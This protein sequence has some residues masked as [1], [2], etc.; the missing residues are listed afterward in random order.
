MKTL[1]F[2]I[3]AILS[4]VFILSACTKKQNLNEKVINII[5]LGEIKGL[6][7]ILAADVGTAAQIGKIYEGLLSYHWLKYPY[8][9][10]PNLAESMPSVSKDGMTYTFK[11]RKGVFFQDNEAFP[12]G[13]GRELEANDFVY[14]IKR[15]ADIKNQSTGWWLLDGKIKGLNDWRTK[16]EKLPASNYLDEIEGLKAIDKYTLQFTLAKK[17]PQFLYSLAMP[18]TFVVAKEVVEKYG[19]EFQNHPVGTGPFVLPKFDQSKRLVFTKNPTF[20]EKF[21]PNDASPEFKHLLTDAGKK[22]PFVDKIVIDIMTESQPGWLKFNKGEVDYYGIPKDSFGATILDGK[23]S[24]EMVNRGIGLSVTPLLETYYYGFNYDIKLFQNINLRRA[25][26]LAYDVNQENKL[27][28]NNTSFVAHSITP[29][30]ITGYNSNFKSQWKGPNLELAKKYLTAAG[31]PNGKGLPEI[32]LDTFSSTTARQKGE[33]FQKQ[34]AQIGIKIKVIENPSP[35]LHAKIKKRSVQMFDYGWIADY[36]D[37]ENFFQL[38]YSKN[39]SPGSNSFNYN[40][41][42]FD[43]E[44]LAAVTMQDSS[45]R[46]ARYEKLNQFLADEAIIIFNSHP[47]SYTLQQGWLKNYHNG[48]FIYD[49]YQYLDVDLAKKKELLEKF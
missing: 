46:T 40:N 14:S 33:F 13:K 5:A 41:A 7:P 15:I 3:S 8:E 29:P 26:T 35:E 28:Y 34:M 10:I 30:G 9:L 6:D 48:D 11:I 22:L 2:F 4:V 39:A 12:G 47:Q 19:M 32:T 1:S 42:K 25:M 20:R 18:F 45:V 23:L 31:F 17:F 44:F 38:F 27:F 16:Y 21:Y 24:P 36:P 43:E 49:Y 37:T